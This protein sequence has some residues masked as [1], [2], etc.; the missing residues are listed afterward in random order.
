[1]LRERERNKERSSMYGHMWPLVVVGLVAL[2]WS[3]GDDADDV[4]SGKKRPM[5]M[6]M[7]ILMSEQCC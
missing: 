1:M 4:F 6:A 5:T 2:G 3:S 7:R